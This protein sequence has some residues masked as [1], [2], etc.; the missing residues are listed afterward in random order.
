ML[1]GVIRMSDMTAGDV[2]V[3]P[4]RAWIDLVN[5]DAPFDALLHLIIDTR[6]SRCSG[7]QGKHRPGILL[8]GLAQNC[9]APDSTSRRCCAGGVVPESEPE[10]P[11]AGLRGS[12]S[13]AIV[14]DGVWPCGGE[15]ITVKTC[16]NKS[17]ARSE[18]ASSTCRGR[19]DIFGLPDRTFRVG[20]DTSIDRVSEGVLASSWW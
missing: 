10:R 11:A 19:G 5:I 15:L 7:G 9:N 12:R 4:H 13:L 20:G 8:W 6:T 14:I 17:L 2:M 18:T 3:A 16:W 1:E